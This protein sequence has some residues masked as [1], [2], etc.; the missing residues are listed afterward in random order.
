MA[1][2]DKLRQRATRLL[3]LALNARE[4]GITSASELEELA[5]EGIIHAEDME[6][7]GAQQQSKDDK[8]E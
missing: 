8:K 3:A 6:R 2:P 4:Q 1:D 7:Q 5:H